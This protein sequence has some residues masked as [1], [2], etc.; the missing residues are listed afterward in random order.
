[1]NKEEEKIS[2]PKKAIDIYKIVV[3]IIILILGPVIVIRTILEVDI[4][5]YGSWM[6]IIV[7]LALFALGLYRL[8]LI[9]SIMKNK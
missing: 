6:M 9:Y 1:M 4:S 7:G 8:K 5:S 3:T 2:K